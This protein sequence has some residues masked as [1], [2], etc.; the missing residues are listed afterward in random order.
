M[1]YPDPDRRI[2]EKLRKNRTRSE[3]WE[4]LPNELEYNGD[5]GAYMIKKDSLSQRWFITEEM[6]CCICEECYRDFKE[7]FI[8][9]KLDGYDIDWSLRCPKCGTKLKTICN[10]DYVYECENCNVLY[11]E[12]F[13]ELQLNDR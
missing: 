8:W 2:L 6:D 10:E 11:D 13:D 3:L 12:S 1:V 4:N 5:K 9:K 7:M